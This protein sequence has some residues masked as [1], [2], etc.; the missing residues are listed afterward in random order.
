M[1]TGFLGYE[2]N[3]AGSLVT[4]FL[5]AGAGVITQPAAERP[6]YLFELYEFEG[7][8]YCRLVREALTELDLDTLVYP[9]PKGG[10]RFRPKVISRGGKAQFPYLVDP[11]TG[12]EMYESAEIVA[13]LFETYGRRALPW[14]WRLMELQKLGSG[15]A[16]L[17]R[18]GAGMNARPS[19]LPERPLELYSFEASP[20]AR[21][22]RE[23]LCELE[24]P[25]VLRSVGRSTLSDWVPP[26]LREVLS[27]EPHPET[28]NRR[29]LLERSGRLS[30]PYL[31]DPNTGTELAES[32]D[33]LEYLE[34]TYAV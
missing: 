16:G 15:I 17:A 30:I 2:L 11:N 18:L 23:L 27:V 8:P 6:S 28:V 32:S 1:N 19:R 26:T 33:I 29:A 31:V 24:L 9:C 5:R 25:Y 12:R 10:E 7:C 3:L 20:F 13:Y 22:V 14:Y 4:T 34:E 21:P